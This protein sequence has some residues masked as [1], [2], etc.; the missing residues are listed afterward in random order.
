MVYH[1]K[2]YKQRLSLADKSSALVMLIAIHMVVFVILAFFKAVYH[3]KFDTT[4]EA[5]Q[6]FNTNILSLFTLPADMHTVGVRPWTVITHMFTE[7]SIWTLF[8]NMLWLWVFGYM[9][10]DLTGNRK[11]FPVFIYGA[12]AGAVAFIAATHLIPSLQPG[13]SYASYFGASSGV[14]AI[15]LAVTA[16]S[17]GYRILPLLKGGIPVWV[18]TLFYVAVD[19]VSVPLNNPA[20]HIAHLAGALTGFLFIY[21]Y[22]K[23]YDMG[24]WMNNLYD[25]INNLFNPDKPKKNKSFKEELFYKADKKPY[26]RTP[27]ITPQRI[28]EILDKINQQG[29]DSLSEDEKELLKRASQENL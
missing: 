27:N 20:L 11:I 21:F 18:L 13:V 22:R 25:W 6:S 15:A 4:E 24:E 23:G 29:Y 10:Q 14:M 1:E 5:V 26:K 17:P 2:Q 9:L 8:G 7:N 3:L 12:L 28:D 19:L 16:I